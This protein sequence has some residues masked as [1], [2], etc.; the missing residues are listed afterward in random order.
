MP[1]M[2]KF[3][4]GLHCLLMRNRSLEK[5]VFLFHNLKYGKFHLSESTQVNRMSRSR[6]VLATGGKQRILGLDM[7]CIETILFHLDSL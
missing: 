1:H 4:Q 3:H 7:V 6:R 5:N 2:A